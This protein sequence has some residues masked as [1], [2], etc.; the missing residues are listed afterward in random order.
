MVRQELAVLLGHR[1]LVGAQR[2]VQRVDLAEERVEVLLIGGGPVGIGL[3]EGG[4]DL[5][6]VRLRERRVGPQVRVRLALLLRE[7]EVVDVLGL[8]EGLRP[9]LHLQRAVGEV[10]LG[11][12]LGGLLQLQP[13]DEQH[14]R[15]RQD[16]G[17]RRRRVE[18]VAV[19]ALRHQ[20]DDVGP[21]AGD[22]RDDR[23]QASATSAATCWT[24]RSPRSRPPVRRSGATR[25]SAS[26]RS[27]WRCPGSVAG[28]GPADPSDGPGRGPGVAHHLPLHRPYVCRRVVAGRGWG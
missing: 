27:T 4:G 13:V 20:T 25:A 3:G 17:G 22:V 6:R 15:V 11:Q 28:A 26:T 18:G 5:L 2:R 14:V 24:C 9:E 12:L 7:G 19:G 1:L 23:G 10:L 16:G 8:G 21:V